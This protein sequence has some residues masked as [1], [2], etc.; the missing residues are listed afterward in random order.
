[1]RGDNRR[2]G[3]GRG[4]GG[5]GG[6]RGGGDGRGDGGRGGYRGG[7][8]GRGDGGRGGYRGGGG[9]GGGRGGGFVMDE[10]Y[11][12]N[13]IREKEAIT[14][15]SK[16]STYENQL[17]AW[18]NAV[19]LKVEAGKKVFVY[20]L[21]I[22]M[23]DGAPDLRD[24]LKLSASKELLM[25]M[26]KSVGGAESFNF[27]FC[28]LT[29]SS[30]LSNERL[31][32]EDFE[33]EFFVSKRKGRGEGT[34]YR[35]VLRLQQ[36]KHISL[37]TRDNIMELNSVIGAAVQQ[38]YEEKI[39][40][41]YVDLKNGR[42]S[43][44]GSMNIFEAI[45]VNAFSSR[46]NGKERDL[47]RLDTSFTVTSSQNC[48][49]ALED[50]K[51]RARGPLRRALLERFVKKKVYS[52]VSESKAFLYKITD[53]TDKKACEPAGLQKN[54]AQT[55]VEYFRERYGLNIDPNQVLF[56][57]RAIPG[58]KE[59]LVPPEVLKEM[60]I[61][62]HDKRYVAQICSIFPNDR[63]DRLRK[64]LDRLV[65]HDGGKVLKFLEAY[66]INIE[67]EFISIKGR[68]LNPVE[69]L[70]P[71]GD[72]FRIVHTMGENSQQGFVRDLRDL[73]HPG[74][75]LPV[76]VIIFDETRNRQSNLVV[77]NV[78]RHLEAINAPLN[79]GQ[80][81]LVRGLG[82]VKVSGGR[83]VVGL[84][85]FQRQEKEAYN[86]WKTLWSKKGVLSQVVVKDLA[87]DREAPIVM[88]VAQQISA[89]TGRLN[90]VI[91]VGKSCP[92]L[93]KN[94]DGGILII[95]ADVGRDQQSFSTATSTVRQDLYAVAFVAFYAKGTQW[96]TYCN[97]YQVDGRKETVYAEGSSEEQST[98]A[99]GRLAPSEVISTKIGEFL[100]DARRH[101]KEKALKISSYLIL[102]GCA[103]EGELIE[104]RKNDA[105]VLGRALEGSKWAIVAAQR[106]Q[107]S[108][109]SAQFSQGDREF[110]NVPRG[111]VT[112]DAVD[113]KFGESFF[114]TGANCTLGHARSTL[115][116]VF[117]RNKFE[118]RELQALVYGM[119]YM[120]PNKTDALPIPL[121]LKCASEY[122]RKYSSLRTVKTLA[123]E[124]RPTMHYL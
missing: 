64:I 52:A 47:L 102:R 31:P 92:S 79:F 1:M 19:P 108:R 49:T 55:Y 100:Q 54:P 123:S 86:D 58:R 66:G 32:A 10:S 109:F 69:V 84:T 3:G 87:G 21:S 44:T 6:Y 116:V 71:K 16:K 73:R 27:G 83:N 68:V 103:S 72:G 65:R 60:S 63:V 99:G 56:K 77:E 91:D 105:E 29:G 50:E 121:P 80:S 110:C 117:R 46:V 81:T 23:R 61:S 119:C 7:G 67:T 94:D 48:L 37:N 24:T 20:P 93:L 51:R 38:C 88:A 45:S 76:D 118:M 43:A 98:K 90:W 18:T 2:G 122:G 41:K 107:H 124:L 104:A 11:R 14:Y 26:R 39:G 111:F 30:I 57:C 28:V 62:D 9:R 114:L 5:R 89:K 115:Y 85:F 36:A 82:E 74:S 101:F 97:H 22:E 35:Y 12:A 112:E 4:D 106:Y 75:R 70:I 13:Q 33:H 40:S 95:A 34:K 78:K 96:S 113:K 15:F 120:Y 59:V 25:K 8:G 42:R 17:T 53:I